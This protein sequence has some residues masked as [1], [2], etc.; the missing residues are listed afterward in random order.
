MDN[1]VVEDEV[2]FR[3]V[4]SR[5][6]RREATTVFDPQDLEQDLWVFFL[7][8][9]QSILNEGQMVSLLKKQAKALTR[10]ERIDYMYFRGAYLYTPGM[11]RRLL[12]NAV[13]CEVEN[14]VDIEGRVDVSTAL[15]ELSESERNLLYAKYHLG[16]PIDNSES[17][18]RAVYRAVDKI[19]DILNTLSDPEQIDP[20]FVID[21][22]TLGGSSF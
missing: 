21:P 11:V 6:A 10:K 15:K 8:R 20:T 17:N 18:R 19:T 4:I 7:E 1:D 14:V 12:E 5:I 2:D 22:Q 9:N 16:E 13:W 3:E